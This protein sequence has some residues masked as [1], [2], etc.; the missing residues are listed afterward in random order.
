MDTNITIIGAG[1]VGLA[2]AAELSKYYTDIYVIERH[3]K[4]GQETSSRNSEVIHSGIYY[5]QGSLKA[6]MC[7]EGKT[8]LYQYCNE[9]NIPHK[10]IGKLIVATDKEE[11]IQ[12]ETIYKQ[13]KSNGVNDHKLLNLEET[14]ALEP[15]IN[16]FTS[17]FFPTTGIIDVSSLMKQLE[18]DACLN[19]TQ[20]VYGT[21][22]TQI[23]K[24]NHGYEVI[25][26]DSDNNKYSFTT[27]I[28]I[29]AAGLDADTV[30]FS[31]GIMDPTYQ[32]YYCKGDYFSIINGKN[33]LLKHLIYPVP[34]RDKTSLGIHSTLDL[35]KRLKLGPDVTYL[36]NREI[37]YQ[38]N[39][40]SK[41]KFYES[42]VKFLPFI[43]LND[44]VPDQ[45]GI[46]PK[47]Q[48]QGDKVRD[49][50]IKEESNNGYP[51]FVN[52][53]GIESPGLTSC[54]AIA[55]YVKSLLDNSQQ[56]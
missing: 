52:L 9:K 51:G 16:A 45:A 53:I 35:T 19:N 25:I 26:N 47:L 50:I 20:F 40:E 13:A 22:V 42:A 18:T 46:R 24:I 49:F 32:L 5:P 31:A 38:V 17:I 12:L 15:N 48:G 55:K 41:L 36:N 14:K 4:F 1:V 56:L 11:V 54:L 27:K 30:S 7:V 28:V 8:L 29:N 39:K 6:K 43:E 3:L 34:P 2:I 44:L 37:I 33:K 10:A 23:K 21:E